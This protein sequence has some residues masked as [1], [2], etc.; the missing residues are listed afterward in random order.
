[1]TS[2]IR[3]VARFSTGT[4][5][6]HPQHAYRGRQPM[7]WW[8]LTSREWQSPRPINVYVIEH[9]DGIVLFDTG[10][11]RKSVTDPEYF[12]GGATGILYRRLA[13]FDIAQ[14]ETVP[15]GLARLG[16]RP[17]DVAKAV[18][19]HLHQDHIGGVRDI[20]QAELL[21][22]STEWSSLCRPLAGPRG[23]LRK[24]VEL[25]GLKWTPI[26]PTPLE[27]PTLAAFAVGH[28][29][30]GDGSLILLPTPGHT[31]GSMS[32]LVC[33]GDG[34]P[35]LLVGDLTYDV[36]AFEEGQTGGVGSRRRLLWTRDRVLAL[37]E[38][39]PGLAI[40]AAHDPA[41][42]GLLEA[43]TPRNVGRPRHA[44]GPQ[45]A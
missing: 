37:R 42:A 2:P 27:D 6:I 32:M 12:P 26:E 19:S 34:P 36:H 35:L 38:S 18:V 23:M 8:M 10:Q 21:V 29:V 24:H 1:M 43:A 13:K 45:A 17:R 28:D 30:F 5:D 44:P 41:A 9:T 25:P 40:L 31:A 16:Y 3:R 14:D 7:Y 4:V 15:A 11:D 22:S 39:H 33:R 20:P